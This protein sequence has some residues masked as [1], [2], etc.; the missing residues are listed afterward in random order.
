ML[1]PLTD[2]ILAYALGFVKE[3]LACALAF[4]LDIFHEWIANNARGGGEAGCDSGAR[5][6]DDY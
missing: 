3:I 1:F 5:A 2:L 4:V 6:S